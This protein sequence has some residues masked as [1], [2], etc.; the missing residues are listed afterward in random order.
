MT[1]EIKSPIALRLVGDIHGRYETYFKLIEGIPYSLQLGDMG[2]R[3]IPLMEFVDPERHKFVPGN[4]DGYHKELSNLTEAEVVG[5]R[6]HTAIGS[7][8]VYRFTRL[9]PHFLGHWGTWSVPETNKN[10]FYVR[11]A[12]SIDRKYRTFGVDWF[13]EEQLSYTEWQQCFKDYEKAKPEFVVSHD[14]PF[15]LLPEII[16]PAWGILEQSITT[17]GLA[18][19]W[20]RHQPRMWVF[21]HF[22]KSW[23][24]KYGNTFFVCL[25]INETLDLDKELKI[26]SNERQEPA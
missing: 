20:N 11:G 5:D 13:Q 2:F 25:N 18:E 21:A 3:Y 23:R 19:L 17:A 7:Q 24:R 10:I 6:F 4:H 16:N 14:A 12:S 9:P 26:I 1:P 15:F 8:M 22:H